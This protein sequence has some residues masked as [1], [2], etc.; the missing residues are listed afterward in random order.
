MK[1][2]QPKQVENDLSRIYENYRDTLHQYANEI[3]KS[4]IIPYLKEK[5]LS[6]VVMN[7]WPEVYNKVG[8]RQKLPKVIENLCNICDPTGDKI[9]YYFRDYNP[10][11]QNFSDLSI[12]DYK[13]KPTHNI[14]AYLFSPAMC[15]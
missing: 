9:L 5:Q 3:M 6:F 4:K 7:G 12:A 10:F 2:Y 1:K 8:E 14:V 11:D 15:L 13:K